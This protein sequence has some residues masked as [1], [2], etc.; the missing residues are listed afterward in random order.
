[1]PSSIGITTMTPSEKT[2]A[3]HENGGMRRKVMPGAR[4][5]RIEVATEL[6]LAQFVAGVAA[7]TIVYGSLRAL[8]QDDLKRRLAFS[9]V[10]QLSYIAW[11]GNKRSKPT[12]S[13][14]VTARNKPR[15]MPNA[16]MG[17]RGAA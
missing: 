10:S 5:V 8:Q 12:Q 17:T 6:G 14:N 9:T 3:D 16:M 11:P 4:V 1:M 7:V 2:N 15:L 13:A